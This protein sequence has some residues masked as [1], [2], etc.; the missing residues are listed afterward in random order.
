MTDAALL[1]AL[2]AL[3]NETRN[4]GLAFTDETGAL[5]RVYSYDLAAPLRDLIAR[6]EGGAS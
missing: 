2:A 4:T 5:R 1:R 6:T 3:I